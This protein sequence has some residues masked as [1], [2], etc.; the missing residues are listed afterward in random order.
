VCP[1][2]TDQKLSGWTRTASDPGHGQLAQ[3]DP[4]LTPGTGT[5]YGRSQRTLICAEKTLNGVE[6]RPR[7]ILERRT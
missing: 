3:P 6:R 1:T 5:G 2:H 4:D 7:E